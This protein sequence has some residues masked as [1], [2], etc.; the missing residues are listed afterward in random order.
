MTMKQKVRVSF[1][2]HGA[3][4]E[5]AGRSMTKGGHHLD[6]EDRYS[7]ENLLTLQGEDQIVGREKLEPG[8]TL[9]HEYC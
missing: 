8:L 6:G 5:D 1:G 2:V 4:G 7:V 3:A 9:R